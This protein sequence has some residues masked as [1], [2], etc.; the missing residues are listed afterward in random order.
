LSM[1]RTLLLKLQ[2][3]ARIVQA[4]RKKSTSGPLFASNFGGFRKTKPCNPRRR[5]Q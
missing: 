2:Q 1:F 3:I 5:E 4:D